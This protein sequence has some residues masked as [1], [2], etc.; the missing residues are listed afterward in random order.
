[1]KGLTLVKADRE[2]KRIGKPK[3]N[4]VRVATKIT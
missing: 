1:L 4:V 3:G 2:Q